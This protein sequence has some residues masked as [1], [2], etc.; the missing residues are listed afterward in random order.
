MSV[1][2]AKFRVVKPITKACSRREPG[3]E[4]FAGVDGQNVKRWIREGRVVRVK[5][6]EAKK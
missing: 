5:E 4:F 6:S 1:K 3:F 2:K